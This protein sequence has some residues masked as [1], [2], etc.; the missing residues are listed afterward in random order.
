MRVGVVMGTRPEIIKLAPVVWALAERHPD[1]ECRV[2]L[3]GQ[4]GR[5]AHEL[6]AE[7][8]VPVHDDLEVMA[9]HPGDLLARAVSGCDGWIEAER[10]DAVVVQG[11]TTSVLAGALAAFY[12][13][14]PVA[15]VEAGLRTGDLTRPFPEEANRRLVGGI[16]AMHFAP[17]A[18][19]RDALLA[20]AVPSEAIV[21]VGN[22]V[23]DAVRRYAVS[24]A[25]RGPGER[26][27]L[28]TIHR[29]ESWGTEFEQLCLGVADLADAEPD[30]RVDFVMH[31]NPALQARAR[32][33]LGHAD[34][35]RLLQPMTYVPFVELLS[36]AD[37]VLT[38][39]G[40]I[41]EEAA[42]LGTPLVVLREVT[43]RPEGVAAGAAFLGGV[44]REGLASA[45]EEA[46][47]A[48]RGDARDLYG[49]GHAGERIA[50]MLAAGR[51]M[52]ERA[53][54]GPA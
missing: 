8:G 6:C 12:R 48:G 16:A 28:V 15:H 2:L 7:L 44:T 17:T 27:A 9:P 45:V 42:S 26:R 35:I 33:T 24:D 23:V 14:V 54:G 52:P 40:G 34:R 43:E 51:M 31:P 32:E 13:K 29:R 20:E 46:L 11:D 50:D 22:T 36:A 47:A 41:Q 5:F 4:H 18:G 25:A 30:L 37:V 19:A 21:V 3:T 53:W 39:S 49:D 10:P 1:V 38:D